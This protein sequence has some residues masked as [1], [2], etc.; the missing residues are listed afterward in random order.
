MG[1]T[2]FDGSQWHERSDA[3][4]ARGGRFGVFR[5]QLQSPIAVAHPQSAA[6]TL[7]THQHP[8]AK[9]LI[10]AHMACMHDGMRVCGVRAPHPSL[11]HTP[12]QLQALSPPASTQQLQI[13]NHAHMYACMCVRR[14]C[15][16]PTTTTTRTHVSMSHPHTFPHPPTPYTHTF[17]TSHIPP[18]PPLDDGIYRF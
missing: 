9:I 1:T 6:S 15:P 13:L 3:Q 7:T 4:H 12:N 10:Y 18:P 16:P 2:G 17:H 14:A 11:W 5:H 8:A